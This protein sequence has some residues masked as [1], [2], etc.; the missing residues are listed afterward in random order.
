[1][2]LGTVLAEHEQQVKRSGGKR[3]SRGGKAAGGKGGAKGGSKSSGAAAAAA[4]AAGV[5]IRPKRRLPVSKVLLVGGAT[6][7]PAVHRFVRHM[8][9]LE[10]E[11]EVVDPDLVSHTPQLKLHTTSN[12]PPHL[13]LHALTGLL[14]ADPG[15]RY[16]LGA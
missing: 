14:P 15:S 2:D 6:R 3:G 4:A 8:T 5:Q 12:I 9:G 11:A 13:T 10:A 7:M 16:A 1:M